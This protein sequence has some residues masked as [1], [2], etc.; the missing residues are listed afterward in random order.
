MSN[1][2]CQTLLPPDEKVDPTETNASKQLNTLSKGMMPETCEFIQPT[3]KTKDIVPAPSA[4]ETDGCLEKQWDF[5]PQPAASSRENFIE[6]HGR[7]LSVKRCPPG[8]GVDPL[9]SFLMLRAQQASPV[10]GVGQSSYSILVDL[11]LV[12]LFFLLAFEKKAN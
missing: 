3:V 4:G 2:A 6:D 1:T 5:V 10:G 9:C 7:P 11:D 8:Q 12:Y